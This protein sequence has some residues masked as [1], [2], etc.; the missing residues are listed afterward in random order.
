[1]PVG[2][3]ANPIETL[4][5][6]SM[7][8]LM[9]A[10]ATPRFIVEEGASIQDAIDMAGAGGV[11]HI[12]PGVYWQ[13]VTVEH[14]NVRIMGLKGPGG[15]Q[16]IIKNPGAVNNG[17]NVRAG[18]DNFALSH[19]VVEGFDRNG[20]FL[21]GVN[22]FDIR[23]VTARDNQEY[24][25]FPVRSANGSVRHSVASGHADAGLYVGQGRDIKLTHNEAFDNVI[26]IE[27]SNSD[28]IL[29]S[30]N[31]TYNNTAGILAALL[32]GRMITEANR[33]TI[34]HNQVR[35]NNLPNFADHGLAVGVPKGSGILAVGIDHSLIEHNTVTG[36]QFL[37]IA[38]ASSLV[39]GQLAGFPPEA[40]AG[41]EPNPD[42]VRIE[43]NSVTGNGTVQPD[44]PFPAVDL[45]WDGSGLENCWDKNT[46]DSS[47]PEMLPACVRQP[48][49]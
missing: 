8:N 41:I 7:D 12:K 35:D 30:H 15:E 36:N 43:K 18:A 11:I 6:A 46:Y 9:H 38:L 27:V 48:G 32:P 37:G 19:V 1:M 23:H 49:N 4:P 31:S 29:V 26:G 28:D 34:R 10:R 13:S 17:I 5:S 25:I 22:G 42:F 47:V 24:G 3:E 33:I 2:G 39:L 45:L 16:V 44:L 21:N 14:P 20:V 40:F